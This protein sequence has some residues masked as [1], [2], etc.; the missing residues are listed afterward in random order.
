MPRIQ[1]EI[2]AKNGEDSLKL[3]GKL[4]SPNHIP[5]LFRIAA[6]VAHGII[7]VK[8]SKVGLKHLG[9]KDYLLTFE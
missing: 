5:H 7:A 8:G 9:G 4:L 2:N 6:T 1:L 3:D